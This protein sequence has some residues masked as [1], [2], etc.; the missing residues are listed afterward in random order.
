MAITIGNAADLLKAWIRGLGSTSVP[1]GGEGLLGAHLE[2]LNGY[3][4]AVKHGQAAAANQ[5][6][7]PFAGLNDGNLMIARTDRFGN[8]GSALHTMLL[9]DSFEGTTTNPIRWT[10]TNTTMAATQSTVG[11]LLFNSGAITTINTGYMIK[12]RTLLKMQR[13]PLQGK[14]R[15]RIAPV[16]NS[17]MEIGFMDATT[18]NGANTTGAYWQVLA[19][20]TVKPVVTFIS[21]DTTGTDVRSLLDATKYYTFDVLM[22]DDEATFLIQDTSTEQIIT[23]QTMRLPLSAQRVLSSTAIPFGVRVYNTGTAPATA[24]QLFLVDAYVAILDQNQTKPWPHVLATVERGANANPATGAQLAQWANSAEPA[25]ATLSNVAAGY[26]TLGGKFQF[27]A[28]AG[29]ATDYALFALA[30]PANLVITGVDI[31]TWNTGAASATTPTLL[32][33]SIAVGSTAVSLATATVTRSGLGAQDIPVGAAVGARAQRISKQ[34][35]S[36]LHCQSGRFVHIILRM[37]VGTATASQVIAGM[38]NVEGYFE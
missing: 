36:P 9:H 21:S 16:N 1:G 10:I 25:S 26:S 33:W 4:L 22:D 18:F 19:D 11:G 12:S 13:A 7:L 35:Q 31:E 29:A 20:G 28:V 6:G 37:P 24:P 38:V 34:F 2:D 17:V 8:L 23:R 27:V 15:A 30:V 5:F 14:A 32:T 3:P